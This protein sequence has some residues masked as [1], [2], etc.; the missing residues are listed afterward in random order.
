MQ[1]VLIVLGALVLLV[2]VTDVLWTTMGQGGGFLTRRVT[3]SLWRLLTAV[4]R[5]LDSRALL[6]TG[7]IIITLA[8]VAIWIFLLW[9]GWLLV[10]IGAGEHI[11][12]A[13]TRFPVD[14][15]TRAYFAGMTLFTLGT[16]DII[17]IG[18]TWRFVMSFASLT[19][20]FLITFSVTYLVPVVQAATQKRQLA[21]HISCLGRTPCD[22]LLNAWNGEDC[23]SLTPHLPQFT[24]QLVQLEQ[25]HWTYPVLHYFHSL[26][27]VSS[28]SVMV[29]VLDEAMTIVLVGMRDDAEVDRRQLE[30]TRRALSRFLETLASVYVHRKPDAPPMPSLAP[31]RDRGV[32]VV[33]DET[34]AARVEDLCDH[35][36]LLRALVETYESWEKAIARAGPAPPP[37]E[38]G[39]A[40]EEEERD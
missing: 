8:T 4:G 6:V 37:A 26:G 39:E 22:L 24:A 3:S 29:P 27:A 23:S 30:V 20:L 19:G 13:T 1:V 35:R 7:G 10:F 34:F 17:A 15:G 28:S 31:L 32:P 36:R 40:P 5:V 11:V 14:L 12:D 16:G 38:E 9:L 25:Q 2:Q 33:D 18:P 21:L